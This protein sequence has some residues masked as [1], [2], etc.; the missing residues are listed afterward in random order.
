MKKIYSNIEKE[1]LLHIILRKEDVQT[2]R[3]N[4]IEDKE[5][6]QLAAMRL[7][8]GKVFRPHK[9]IFCDRKTAIV[10]ESWVVIDGRVKVFL[11]R[12][13][14]SITLY[15]GHTYQI[16]EDDT[17]VYEYKTGPYEGIEKDKVF[18]EI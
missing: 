16:L 2:A 14:C 5:F 1:K 12:G 13:D 10:Q 7:P 17:L 18:L 4:V 8:E 11:N 6:L 3:L 9:H 15:G